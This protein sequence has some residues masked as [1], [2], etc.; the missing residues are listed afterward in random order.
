MLV[1]EP[2]IKVPDKQVQDEYYGEHIK[3]FREQQERLKNQ[4][5][6]MENALNSL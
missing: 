5:K 6:D 2:R 4:R 1:I 3:P